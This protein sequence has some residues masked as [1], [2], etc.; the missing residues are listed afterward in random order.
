MG[1]E[2]K[3]SSRR[4]LIDQNLIIGHEVFP[5]SGYFLCP[6]RPDVLCSLPSE[7]KRTQRKTPWRILRRIQW[8][9]SK[10]WRKQ[11]LQHNSSSQGGWGSR[12]GCWLWS[13][14]SSWKIVES[15]L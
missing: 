6:V 1:I 3:L 10:H 2:E 4:D 14:P 5:I 15:V 11:L 9:Q 8:I 13:L 12:F 7:K